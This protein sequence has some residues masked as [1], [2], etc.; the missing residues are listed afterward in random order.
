MTKLG[1]GH[2]FPVIRNDV[3]YAPL[4]GGVAYVSGPVLTFDDVRR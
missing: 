1:G 3:R 2:T 4:V